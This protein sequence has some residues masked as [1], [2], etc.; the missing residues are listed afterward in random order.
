MKSIS[1]ILLHTW[2]GLVLSINHLPALQAGELDDQCKLDAPIT[3][4]PGI[5]EKSECAVSQLKTAA[6]YVRQKVT[7]MKI[8]SS[9]ADFKNLSMYNNELTSFLASCKGGGGLSQEDLQAV[10]CDTDCVVQRASVGLFM[11]AELPNLSSNTGSSAPSDNA[12]FRAADQS[13]TL[14]NAA[15]ER[16]IRGDRGG[17]TQQKSE[18][19]SSSFNQFLRDNGRLITLKARLLMAMGDY[20]YK[21]TSRTR[22]TVLARKSQDALSLTGATGPKPGEEQHY[23]ESYYREASWVLQEGLIDVPQLDETADAGDNDQEPAGA[24]KVSFGRLRQELQSLNTDVSTRLQSVRNGFLFLNIDPEA[25][26]VL[27]AEELQAELRT[28]LQELRDIEDKIGQITANWQNSKT[29]E[30]RRQIDAQNLRDDRTLELKGMQ[31]ASYEDLADEITQ[32]FQQLI[33]QNG[34]DKALADGKVELIE[35]ESMLSGLSFELQRLTKETQ[36]QIN[37]IRKQNEIELTVLAKE[38]HQER[39]DTYKWLIDASL[40]ALNLNLQI[41]EFNAQ[42]ADYENRI[43]VAGKRLESLQASINSHS[44][45][46][47]MEDTKI[48]E[49]D[50]AL[51]KIGQQEGRI[52]EAQ[53]LPLKLRICALGIEYKKMI[54]GSPNLGKA[55][56]S[57]ASVA[58]SSKEHW[59]AVINLRN[60]FFGAG[61]DGGKYKE[62]YDKLYKCMSGGSACEGVS[63]SNSELVKNIYNEKKTQFGA[64]KEDINSLTKKLDEMIK[65][66]NN[67][68]NTVHGMKATYIGINAGLGA[69]YVAL[70]GKIASVIPSMD[71]GEQAKA[72]Y[73]LAMSS[74]EK[75]TDMVQTDAQY[76][77]EVKNLELE[78]DTLLKELDQLKFQLSLDELAKNQALAEIIGRGLELEKENIL[79]KADASLAIKE[80][81]F[82]QAQVMAEGSRIQAEIDSL[83]AEIDSIEAETSLLVHEK[84]I[85]N[86]QKERSRLQKESLQAEIDGLEADKAGVNFEIKGYQ[87]LKATADNQLNLV[88]ATKNEVEGLNEEVKLQQFIVDDL[89]SQQKSQMSALSADQIAS[90]KDVLTLKNTQIEKAQ[91]YVSEQIEQNLKS[92]GLTEQGQALTSGLNDQLSTIFK[93]VKAK[94]CEM[95]QFAVSRPKPGEAS[96]NLFIASEEVITNL[97]QGIPEYIRSKQSRLEYVNYLYNLYRNR[98]SLLSKVAGTDLPNSY[99]YIS[100]S[101][102]LLSSMKRLCTPGGS[103]TKGA[104]WTCDV[105]SLLFSDKEVPVLATEFVIPAESGFMSRLLSKGSV[106]FELTPSVLLGL[107]DVL[108][109]KAVNE[110]LAENGYFQL[111]DSGFGYY[112]NLSLMNLALMANLGPQ[113]RDKVSIT[114]RHLGYGTRFYPISSDNGANIYPELYVTAPRNAVSIVWDSSSEADVYEHYFR[115][116]TKSYIIGELPEKW[117]SY[118][119]PDPDILKFLGAP[120]AGTY[121]IAIDRVGDKGIEPIVAACLQGRSLS[122]GVAYTKPTM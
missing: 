20:Y 76:E 1:N 72:I 95:M 81:E 83:N 31:I 48:S 65:A 17:A 82:N 26:S 23:A 11:I 80:A 47:R 42:V 67:A 61:G 100:D 104:P 117:A 93:E 40:T 36:A 7:L 66:L 121:E 24:L 111:W 41:N 53:I 62:S 43:K 118:N 94:R 57:L 69:A 86:T 3:A 122:L 10:V 74:L 58:V 64:M 27:S 84:N 21:K 101:N 85:L 18:T 51:A 4:A 79:V 9:K 110:R 78:K 119:N 15:L 2:V 52:K 44:A 60:E 109:A 108:D 107:G 38:G 102:S 46:K 77:N 113:C 68:K 5:N 29:D 99:D 71:L 56:C 28:Q 34:Y 105:S 54:S 112:H 97:T 116:M 90:V 32:K 50:I 19:Y 12:G 63:Q 87:S 89:L 25:F 6:S 114:V 103:S 55:T 30:Q 16:L 39:R 92:L 33:A 49:A 37:Q 98:V 75:A 88:N 96:A 8:A 70:A 91:S 115:K 120:L 35:K 106:R 13:L 22:A 45:Q 59:E 73:M 14:V